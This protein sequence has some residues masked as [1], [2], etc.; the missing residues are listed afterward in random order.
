MVV[1]GD[2]TVVVLAVTAVTLIGAAAAD[3]AGKL[4][5]VAGSLLR[6]VGVNSSSGSDCVAGRG[7]PRDRVSTDPSPI[8]T[9]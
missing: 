8:V 3:R 4:A 2:V 5:K 1:A 7:L 6:R 9:S